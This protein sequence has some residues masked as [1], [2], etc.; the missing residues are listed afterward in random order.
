MINEDSLFNAIIDAA[1]THN[2]AVRNINWTNGLTYCF[3][4][5][6]QWF[7][8]RAVINHANRLQGLPSSDTTDQ[9]KTKLKKLLAPFKPLIKQIPLTANKLANASFADQIEGRKRR[10]E[11]INSPI[12]KKIQ[13]IQGNA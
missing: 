5:D 12:D 9:C 7:P 3:L 1:K 4:Y 8:I 6:G 10:W 13:L 11:A 2:G